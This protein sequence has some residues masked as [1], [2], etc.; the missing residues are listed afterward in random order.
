MS[1]RTS[2]NQVLSLSL[3]LFL[4]CCFHAPRPTHG[5][6]SNT[7]NVCATVLLLLSPLSHQMERLPT[8]S[9]CVPLFC[10]P[11]H[12]W[13]GLQHVQ[14]VCHVLL[15]LSF[16]LVPHTHTHTHTH[17][18][19][20]PMWRH[21][22]AHN[23]THVEPT[24]THTRKKCMPRGDTPHALHTQTHTQRI[25]TWTHTHTHTKR[26]LNEGPI[27]MIRP[28]SR[29]AKKVY[30]KNVGNRNVVVNPGNDPWAKTK[31]KNNGW[32]DTTC[33]AHTHTHITSNQRPFAHKN[34]T[35]PHTT[36]EA[37]PAIAQSHRFHSLL[38][39][40]RT[41]HHE[42]T[43]AVQKDQSPSIQWPP[44]VPNVAWDVQ[45]HRDTP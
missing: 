45:R 18:Q 28:F 5:G 40:D 22:L 16:T 4:L 2:P 21:A 17:A 38:I 3:S 9:M 33:Y 13:S 23:H 44:H 41:S 26:D 15:L 10:C 6:G 12:K 24:H 30:K 11:S 36:I 31:P 34:K 27:K 25:P 35:H 32:I 39:L 37:I 8:H 43:R 19:R 42:I 7:F 29:A 14:C 20:I 1:S